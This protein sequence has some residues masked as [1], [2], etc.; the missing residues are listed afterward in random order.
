[1]RDNWDVREYQHILQDLRFYAGRVDGQNGP[2][3]RDAV[4]AYRCAKGLPPGDTVDDPTW[5]ALIAEMKAAGMTLV[6]Q[7][8]ILPYH[9]VLI[10]HTETRSNGEAPK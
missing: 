1:M 2:A 7:P 4:R 5:D 10:F 6:G 3:T 9:Y 8:D